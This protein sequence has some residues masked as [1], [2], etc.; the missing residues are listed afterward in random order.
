MAI[1]GAPRDGALGHRLAAAGAHVTGSVG[2]ASTHLVIST[3]QPFGRYF[4]ANSTY[5]RALD[6]QKAGG[7]IEIVLEQEMRQRLDGTQDCS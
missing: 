6:L 5:K 3:D 4:H 2:K 1:L 7:K